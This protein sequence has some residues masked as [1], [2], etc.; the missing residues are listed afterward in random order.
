MTT[1]PTITLSST[2]D[3]AEV[4]D[5]FWEAGNVLHFLDNDN[6]DFGDDKDSS[7]SSKNLQ[8]HKI[9]FAPNAYGHDHSVTGGKRIHPDALAKRNLD[10]NGLSVLWV[11]YW[12]DDLGG[13]S[14]VKYVLLPG[15]G[16]IDSDYTPDGSSTAY[17]NAGTTRYC[18]LQ[19]EP[20]VSVSND[21]SNDAVLDIDDGSDFDSSYWGDLNYE[22]IS[23]VVTSFRG[24]GSLGSLSLQNLWVGKKGGAWLVA[25]N[26]GGTIDTPFTYLVVGRYTGIRSGA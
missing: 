1:V 26:T 13:D 5:M 14:T 19:T 2:A 7:A 11:D 9:L 6:L 15:H 17:G 25:T 10:V 16:T 20:G 8:P 3:Q 22:V 4:W 24:T 12:S 18:F 23:V 21:S